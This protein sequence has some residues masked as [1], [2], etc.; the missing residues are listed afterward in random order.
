M[1]SISLNPEINMTLK[2]FKSTF[3]SHFKHIVPKDQPGAMKAEYDRI[4]EE[5]KKLDHDTT[6]E[7]GADKAEESSQSTDS[8]TDDE[9]DG[10]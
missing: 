8:K 9:G 4:M 10:K 1:K 5:R 7:K 3:G 2:E 6:K